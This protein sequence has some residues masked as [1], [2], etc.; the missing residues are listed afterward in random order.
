MIKI[1]DKTPISRLI[2]VAYDRYKERERER[3]VSRAAPTRVPTYLYPIYLRGTR[4]SHA[5]RGDKGLAL[6]TNR[7]RRRVVVRLVA[8]R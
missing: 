4:V 5:E 7:R 6:A 3:S 2:K 1:R 8:T